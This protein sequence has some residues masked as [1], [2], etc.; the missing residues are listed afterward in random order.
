MKKKWIL[1]AMLALA[2]MCVLAVSAIASDAAGTPGLLMSQRA[3][4]APRPL[5]HYNFSIGSSDC[6]LFYGTQDSEQTA[7]TNGTLS[8]SSENIVS[9]EKR[10]G[11]F[12][13]MFHDFGTVTL[14]YTDGAVS[15]S[16]EITVGLPSAGFY[17]ARERTEANYISSTLQLPSDES[18][19]VWMLSKNGFSAEE[20]Q[21][22]SLAF[23]RDNTDY[24]IAANQGAVVEKVLRSDG[25][26]YDFKFTLD[27]KKLA[28]S[29]PEF[30][31]DKGNTV[32]LQVKY[33]S[34]RNSR[35]LN[36]MLEEQPGL[37]YRHITRTGN[38]DWTEVTDTMRP[39]ATLNQTAG[40]GHFIRLYYGT[41][42]S[43]VPVTSAAIT[44]GNSVMFETRTASD[45]AEYWR[46]SNKTF[47]ESELT[48]TYKAG[49]K[50]LTGT[51]VFHIAL[52]EYGF[53]MAPTISE[54]AYCQ[55]ID[56]TK[57]TDSSVWFIRRQGF[58][59]ADQSTITVQAIK[60]NEP[61]HDVSYVWVERDN[62]AGVYD[63][64][65]TL[66]KPQDGG[67]QLKIKQGT[68]NLASNNVNLNLHNEALYPDDDT[69][70][71][72]C[73]WTDD[74]VKV[75]GNDSL[76][77]G[78]TTAVLPD[79][80]TPYTPFAHFRNGAE[81]VAASIHEDSKGATY[82]TLIDNGSASVHATRFWLEP[83]EGEAEAFS[84]SETAYVDEL[85]GDFD[86]ENWPKLYAKN[87]AVARAYLCA[88]VVAKVKGQTISGEVRIICKL[89]RGSHTEFDCTELGVLTTDDL[90]QLLVNIAAT[91]DPNSKERVGYTVRL[92]AADYTGTVRI[93]DG[94][95]G[96][97]SLTLTGKRDGT[98]RL[99]GGVD[100]GGSNPGAYLRYITFIAPEKTGGEMTRAVYNG[101]SSVSYCVFYGYDV[102][103]DSTDA[104]LMAADNSVFIN[105]D[106]AYRVDIKT[107]SRGRMSSPCQNNTFLNNGTAVQVLSLNKFI[108]P[109]Y[110]RIYDSNF[111][112]NETD[113]DAR[114]GGTL[115]LYRNYFGEYKH[116]GNG[117]T[118]KPGKPGHDKH[119][120]PE[121]LRLAMLLAA[122]TEE[123]VGNMLHHRQ[124]QIAKDKENHTKVITNPRWHYPVLN[125]WTGGDLTTMLTGVG[126]E[127]AASTFASRGTYQNVLIADWEQ[128]TVIDNAVADNL[129]IDGS[130]FENEGEKEID[131][132]DESE[133]SLGSWIFD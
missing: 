128:E 123:S 65:F 115:Y 112:N 90:N 71:G 36:I 124:P 46:M 94:F 108:S 68:R 40:M 105:N 117:H 50:T 1:A 110:F 66:P 31:L 17:T 23:R 125:W 109:Y 60:D 129:L 114:S 37:M 95:T 18:L 12:R 88:E 78:Q 116:T 100:L 131:V 67:Y 72:F 47:G 74:I 15:Y 99:I 119:N 6:Y 102:A 14:T 81:I 133:Q 34:G 70:I 39:V 21:G 130:A 111:I 27:G 7:L 55:P 107:L 113:I 118:P 2:L 13:V 79:G 76:Q 98:T 30:G 97:N 3:G 19:T 85:R 59:L 80:N 10:D 44:S 5:S 106:I 87:G 63:L 57:L 11:Y 51:F 28:E 93:P 45:G 29:F 120:G 41:S 48:F 26:T 16:E 77:F 32:Y 75:V 22:I 127:A 61:F 89:S 8:S 58:T 42:D 104:G 54:A 33:R 25:S 69:I 38:G 84:L 24:P 53:Y 92:A 9:V 83:I 35:G 56:W 82:Y 20:A 49:N 52:P 91:V 73:W 86:S 122:K 43:Y 121:E 103:L 62:E 4:E 96:P 101:S 132:V 64:K 126:G